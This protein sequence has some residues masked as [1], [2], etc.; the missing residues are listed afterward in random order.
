MKQHVVKYHLY[1]D[2]MQ[3]Y[4]PFDINNSAE[5]IRKVQDYFSDIRNWM[6]SNFLRL[7]DDKTEFMIL[8]TPKMLQKVSLKLKVSNDNITPS[9]H[10]ILEFYL[11]KIFQCMITFPI[12]A[13][14]PGSN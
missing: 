13:K 1:A 9:K 2:D 11:M 8:G 7:N 10:E 3:I 14:V 4:L 6:C 12:H 5:A